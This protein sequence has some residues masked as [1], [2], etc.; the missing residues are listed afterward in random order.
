MPFPFEVERNVLVIIIIIII[1]HPPQTIWKNNNSRVATWKR[2]ASL[3]N[4]LHLIK[5]THIHTETICEEIVEATFNIISSAT[6]AED[7]TQIRNKAKQYKY[8]K[9]HTYKHMISHVSFKKISDYI[10]TITKHTHTHTKTE[11]IILHARVK[12][13]WVCVCVRSQ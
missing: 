4:V 5:H 8:N 12:L 6:A 11:N 9:M 10:Q 3:A 2:L 13:V 1:V 7:E